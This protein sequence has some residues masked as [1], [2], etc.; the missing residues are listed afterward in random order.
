MIDKRASLPV[1]RQCDL[2]DLNR[3]GIYY[4]LIPLSMREMELMRR[5][6]EIHLSYPFYGSR[7]IRNELWAQG[8]DIGRDTTQL[9]SFGLGRHFCMGASLARLEA[10]VALE[11]FIARFAGYEIDGER[12]RRV[13]STNVRGFATLPT[14]LAAR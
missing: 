1:T 4:K 14:T 9:V 12:S 3:S 2:L 7:K 8:Y 6:D 10:K 13:H 5:I 11:E